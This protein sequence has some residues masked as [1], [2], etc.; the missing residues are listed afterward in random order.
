LAPDMRGFGQTDT[1]SDLSG[2][3][4]KSLTTDL[5]HLLD[6]LNIPKAVFCGHDHG[7]SIVRAL[8]KLCPSPPLPPCA[9]VF[10]LTVPGMENVPA[11]SL[12][13]SRRSLGV[14]SLHSPSPLLFV[15]PRNR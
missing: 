7:G 12:E 11:S 13:G 5:A 14:H 15:Y 3:S 10:P 1:P 6:S 8:P 4:L 9:P 2:Y